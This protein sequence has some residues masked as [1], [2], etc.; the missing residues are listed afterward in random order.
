MR[1]T[2][3]FGPIRAWAYGAAC[4]LAGSVCIVRPTALAGR[5]EAAFEAALA[6]AP[7][8][9]GAL[10][11]VGL[12]VIVW[13]HARTD[14]SRSW[15]QCALA[16]ATYVSLT[17]ALRDWQIDDAAITYA[18]SENL[19]T[20]HGLTILQGQPP[21]EAYSNTIWML[22][23]AGARVLG[24]DVALASKVLSTCVGCLLLVVLFTS[25]R[26]ILGRPLGGPAYA[27][28][29]AACLS[30]PLLVWSVSGLEHG[31][32]ALFLVLLVRGAVQVPGATDHFVRSAAIVG[33]LLVLLR[34]E[35]PLIVALV[36][37]AA[38]LHAVLHAPA[39]QARWRA[40]LPLWPVAVAPVATL[41]ALQWFRWSYFHDLLPNPYYA[42]AAGSATFLRVLSPYGAGWR[43]V[44]DW[45]TRGGGFVLLL[46]FAF[47][48]PRDL[49]RALWIALS[50]F[51][52]QMLF[53]LYA[54]GDWMKHWRFLA[55]PLAMLA[56]CVGYG[57]ERFIATTYAPKLAQRYAVIG[58]AAL[59]LCN[60]PLLIE[61]KRSPT[62]PYAEVSD[63]G[64]TFVALAKVLAIRDPLLAHHDAGGTTY[65]AHIRLL[66]LGGLGTRV[67]AQHLKDREFLRRYILE[68]NKPDFIYGSASNFAA[69]NAELA[70]APR[71][72]ADYVRIEFQGK[73][74][75]NGD[76]CHIRRDR[77]SARHGIHYAS[78]AAG[79]VVVMPDM[80][81]VR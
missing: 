4:L 27:L 78:R 12:A 14:A 11:A 68:E 73:P 52:G 46:V 2:S 81:A 47:Y 56:L 80:L 63:V 62:T 67:V 23:L 55:A 6:V 77:V 24:A 26:R 16:C 66:D 31:L 33:S 42:K 44:T 48:R 61:Y 69:G 18:Y 53:V 79:E 70:D 74:W 9:G 75:M 1:T 40:V 25:L 43:Y 7:S 19:A 38:A 57:V 8:I 45:L 21:E 20:G 39:G 35:A 13:P 37:V 15:L 65:R 36:F 5:F 34:P 76:L 41:A 54:G 72:K 64:Q 22:A 71:F 10:V 29:L 30:E 32:Q 59:T 50:A 49:P 51:A 3:D 28:T 58:V 60:V 17:L